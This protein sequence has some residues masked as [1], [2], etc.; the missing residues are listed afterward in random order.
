MCALRRDG[1]DVAVVTTEEPPNKA[2]FLWGEASPRI[3][4]AFE[5]IPVFG[6]SE[7]SG[8]TIGSADL[9]MAYAVWD[10]RVCAQLAALTDHPKPLLLLQEYEPVFHDNGAQRALCEACYRIPHYP[11]INSRF[12]LAYLER[13][14]SAFSGTPCRRSLGGTTWCSSTR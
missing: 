3:R 11:V 14:G 12:L 9:F 13:H 7:V 8:L 1:H 4:T 10:L 2:Y 5:D 6:M